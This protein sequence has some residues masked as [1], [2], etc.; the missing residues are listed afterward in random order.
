MKTFN[1]EL[2]TICQNVEWQ[3]FTN[4]QTKI[5][6]NDNIDC[7]VELHKKLDELADFIK[8]LENCCGWIIKIEIN[9]I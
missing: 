9:K 3:I 1:F 8:R 7:S 2:K 5:K 6:Y 4:W